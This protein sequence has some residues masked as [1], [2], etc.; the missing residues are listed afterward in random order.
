MFDHS[1][2]WAT[3]QL[4]TEGA[5]VKKIPDIPYPQ[6]VIFTEK[7]VLFGQP[8]EQPNPQVLELE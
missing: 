6:N 7:G 3:F 8:N 4:I 5:R 2:D 1:L